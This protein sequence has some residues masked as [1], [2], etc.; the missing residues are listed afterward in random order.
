MKFFI[1]II[2]VAGFVFFAACTEKSPK[3]LP[4]PPP[5]V[6]DSKTEVAP[7]GKNTFQPKIDILFVIDDSGSM[8]EHQK[9]LSNN[10][11]KF[12]DA[13]VRTTYLDYHVGVVTSSPK[14]YYP[15]CCGKL[16]GTP[17]YVDRNTPNGIYQMAS[18][19]LV[20]T[21][22][23]YEEAFFDPVYL[24]L[25]DPLLSG[26]NAGFYRPEASL[27]LIFIT[28]TEDQSDMQDANSL[29]NFL[30]AIKGNAQKIEVAAA[31]IPE[32]EIS[33]CPGETMELQ[34]RDGLNEFFKLT[35]ALTF[36]LCDDFGE[37]LAIIGEKI[38]AKS[39][40]MYLSKKPVPETI[41]VT[42]GGVEMPRDKVKGWTYEPNKVAIV[43]GS[44][45]EWDLYPPNTFPQID[46]E[47]STVETPKKK[48]D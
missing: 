22:G 21:G 45:I 2:C 44:D 43:F 17:L 11:S 33:S 1:K 3:L 20:G 31:Y 12:A 48:K 13:I 37:E 34:S 46:F 18:N 25:S 32:N 14:G 35:N 36:S 19:I 15:N 10:I 41:K 40:I 47:V 4:K 26:Y 28:D 16:V 5:V 42:M 38:A 23:G 39:Q 27:A 8:S 7:V 29:Y 6:P 24:A 9:N 30:L